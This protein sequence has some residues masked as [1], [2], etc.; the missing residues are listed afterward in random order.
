MLSGQAA[1]AALASSSLVSSHLLL[2]VALVAPDWQERSGRS[3][4]CIVELGAAWL[5]PFLQVGV[6]VAL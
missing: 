1:H 4:S 6:I 3:L 5:F 2:P